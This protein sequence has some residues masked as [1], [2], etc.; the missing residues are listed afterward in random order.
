MAAPINFESSWE[1]EKAKKQV[2]EQ[3]E[4]ILEEVSI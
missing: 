1:K 3:R 2:K 4:W